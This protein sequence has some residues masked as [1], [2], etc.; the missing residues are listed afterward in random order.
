[1]YSVS[2]VGSCF[3]G[4]IRATY[5]ELSA[6]GLV[7]E[8]S[9]DKYTCNFIGVIEGVVVTVYDWK[10]EKPIN[11]DSEFFWNVGGFSIDA[12]LFLEEALFQ[13]F[14]GKHRRDS[15]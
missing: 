8:G 5:S 15:L 13:S 2:A 3:Q 1:M 7:D 9:G 4:N 6:L 12:V 10:N 11:P 14:G